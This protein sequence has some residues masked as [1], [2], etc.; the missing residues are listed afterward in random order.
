MKT[1]SQTQIDAEA[2]Q[3]IIQRD[4]GLSAVESTR[5]AAWQAADPRHADAVARHDEAWTLLDQPRTRGRGYEMATALAHRASRRRRRRTGLSALAAAVVLVAGVLWQTPTPAEGP[6]PT[7]TALV[8]APRLQHL[9]DGS[10]V[11]LK[12]GAEIAVDYAGALR[13]VTL[14][15]GVALFQVAKNPD[16]AFVVTAAG[17]QVR[18]VG[19]AFTVELGR[20]NVDVV[21][22]EG[23]VAVAQSDLTPAPS[24]VA[25]T[26]VNAGKRMTVDFEAKPAVP[27]PIDVSPTEMSDHLAWR[28]TRLEFSETPLAEAIALMNRHSKVQLIVADAALGTLP[29][30]GIF[31][32]DNTETLVRL[33]EANFGVTAERSGDKITLR[34]AR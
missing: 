15:K 10:V 34:K 32:A 14:I 9:P 11:E 23:R 22:T 2:S 33:M 31:R 30:N 3:W 4:A 6:S 13:R 5:F 19:T 25:P 16:R 28:D 7:S 21:V 1:P 17:V 26:F 8:L 20:A 24:P 29:V 12:S 18:A 27:E